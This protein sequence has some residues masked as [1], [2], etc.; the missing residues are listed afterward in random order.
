MFLTIFYFIFIFYFLLSIDD[1]DDDEDEVDSSVAATAPS[2]VV[3]ISVKCTLDMRTQIMIELIFNSNMFMSQ[4][5]AMELGK[6][7]NK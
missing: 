5:A 6:F 3:S 7:I 4:M 1:D 2:L